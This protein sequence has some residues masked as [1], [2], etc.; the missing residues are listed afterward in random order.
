MNVN[1]IYFLFIICVYSTKLFKII[2]FEHVE[3]I[4]SVNK[5]VMCQKKLSRHDLHLLFTQS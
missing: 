1:P 3:I 4:L 2:L 5:D